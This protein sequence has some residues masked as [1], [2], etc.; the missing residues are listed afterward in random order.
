MNRMEEATAAL[1]QT[2]SAV[3]KAKTSLEEGMTSLKTRQ[4]HIRIADRSEYGW[5]AVEEYVEDE[6]ADG[7]DDEKRIQ[8]V[9]FRA[10]KSLS[11]S[12]ELKIRRGLVRTS[13]QQKTSAY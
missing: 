8:R 4:K 1:Q 6:L 11:L 12:R 10:G 13:V 3:E 5:A 9:D 2:P 7:E